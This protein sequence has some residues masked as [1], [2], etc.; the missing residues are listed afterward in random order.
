MLTSVRIEGNVQF[1]ILGMEEKDYTW[2]SIMVNKG[3]DLHFIQVNVAL[4]TWLEFTTRLLRHCL[5]K[6]CVVAVN[7]SELCHSPTPVT[8][9]VP[10]KDG[11]IRSEF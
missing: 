4:L 3:K 1:L 10:N 5:W 7:S 2:E 9:C 6:Y 8:R 11:I